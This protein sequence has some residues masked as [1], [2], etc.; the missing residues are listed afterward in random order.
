MGLVTWQ[1]GRH[2]LKRIPK[3][4]RMSHRN[5]VLKEAIKKKHEIVVIGLTHTIGVLRI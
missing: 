1:E 4:I 3:Y 2:V 5:E